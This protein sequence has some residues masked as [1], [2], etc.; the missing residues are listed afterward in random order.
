M[1]IITII[2]NFNTV[3]P[4]TLLLLCTNIYCL[5]PWLSSR[6]SSYLRPVLSDDLPP[7][8]RSYDH[9]ELQAGRPKQTKPDANT[10][11]A[12]RT[13]FRADTSP[14]ALLIERVDADDGGIYRCR[15]DYLLS[16]TQNKKVNLTVIGK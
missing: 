13:T 9:R 5:T 16:P 12:R 14:A 2:I 11:L 15:V 8:P 6:N 7:L 4:Y 10:T 3:L 1:I